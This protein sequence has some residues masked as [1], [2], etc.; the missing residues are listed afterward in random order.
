MVSLT[1]NRVSWFKFRRVLSVDSTFWHHKLKRRFQ[2]FF[3]LSLVPLAQYPEKPSKPNE[4]PILL[5]GIILGMG[6]GSSA[7]FMD[8]SVKTTDDLF[9]ATHISLLAPE[10]QNEEPSV[11]KI[12]KALKNA[13]EPLE[14]KNLIGSMLNKVRADEI[15]LTLHQR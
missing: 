2:L 4:L 11:S 14:G 9:G 5:V 3:P 12:E 15:P 13:M 7:K 1:R 6:Y 8:R 10:C